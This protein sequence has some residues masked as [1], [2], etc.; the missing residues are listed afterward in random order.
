MRGEKGR[1][2]ETRRAAFQACVRN[3]GR[4]QGAANQTPRLR[5]RGPTPLRHGRPAERGVETT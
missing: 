1:I 5:R 2:E 4:G 3:G